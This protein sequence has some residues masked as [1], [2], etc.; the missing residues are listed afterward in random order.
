MLTIEG[1]PE[2]KT[3]LED[4]LKIKDSIYN[5]DMVNKIADYK[6]MYA[7]EKKEAENKLLIEKNKLN[8]TALDAKNR[9]IIGLLIGVL[10]IVIT[11]FWRISV[12][13]LKKKS[14]ELEATQKIQ[15]E[16]ERIS[17][18][19]HDNVGGQLSYVLYSLDGLHDVNAVKRESLTSS[20]EVSV[21]NVI[22]NLRETIWAIND[23]SI[24]LNDFS[25]KLKVYTRN[26]FR[27]TNTNVI[28]NEKITQN[29]SFNSVKGLNL[30]R[31]CQEIIN[32]AF[33]HSNASQLEIDIISDTETLV[34]ITDNGVGFALEHIGE[35]S[36]GL[37]NIKGRAKDAEITLLMK[38]E[39][40]KGTE[41]KLIV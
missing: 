15:K 36:Y 10:L 38:S 16:K 9:T 19:L 23:E 25:D 27:Y 35:E 12:M 20:I 14:K 7:T 34:K 41:Y 2:I 37:A 40:A 28:F 30:Y 31:I 13:N 17:R 18:D 26:M 24:N 6:T 22:G 32:N 8:Q 39:V 4:Y 1:D 3:Y 33:K 11:V 21:R 29:R 5:A